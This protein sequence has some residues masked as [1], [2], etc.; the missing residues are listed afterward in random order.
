MFNWKKILLSQQTAIE[1]AIKVIDQNSLQVALVVD[2]QHRLLGIVT[3]GDIRRGIL[4]HIELSE[5]ISR[6]MNRHP[7]TANQN[8]S[9]TQILNQ[10]HAE[11]IH[12]MPIVDDHQVVVGLETL[13]HLLAL[14]QQEHAVVI[15]AGGLG[16]RLMPYTNECPKPLLKV[17]EKSILEM[18]LENLASQGLTEI[19]LVINYKGEMIENYLKDGKTYGVNITYI[20]EQ[21]RLGTAGGL[22]LLPVDKIKHPFIVTNADLITNINY[23]NLLNFHLQNSAQATMCVKPYKMEIP[24]GVVQHEGHDFTQ[25]FEKPIHTYLVNAGIY[26]LNP[27]ILPYI[28]NN[29]I[30]DMVHLF[31]EVTSR[32]HKVCTFALY[33]GWQDVGSVH[34]Y[35]QLV[36]QHK[37][38]A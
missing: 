29:Q 19:Y 21:E 6:I 18:I 5:P 11:S 27:E 32:S 13:D 2:A 17:G 38:I 37:E 15:M 12:H 36:S 4:Q 23:K 20:R 35:Q 25:I 28:P 16:S 8:A 30:Y 1:E 7:K 9:R 24:Y 14:P 22:S 34:D 33:E 31:K 3:D 10:M 26:V